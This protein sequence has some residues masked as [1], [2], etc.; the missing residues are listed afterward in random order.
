MQYHGIKDVSNTNSS[1]PPDEE[2]AR[3]IRVCMI[4][5]GKNFPSNLK[6]TRHAHSYHMI[7]LDYSM[8]DYSIHS[9]C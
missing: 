2:V 4:L 5:R 6:S 8:L 9:F 7:M 1:S 3:E